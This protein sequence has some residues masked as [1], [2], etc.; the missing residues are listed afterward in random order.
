MASE[1]KNN[2]IEKVTETDDN[3]SFTTTEQQHYDVFTSLMTGL[4]QALAD[5]RGDDAILKKHTVTM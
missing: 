5:A 2:T 1:I 3:N 4:N